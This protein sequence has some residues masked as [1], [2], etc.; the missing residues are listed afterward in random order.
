MIDEYLKAIIGDAQK[1]NEFQEKVF[2]KPDGTY[3]FTETGFEISPQKMEEKK[4]KPS[5]SD[6]P[7]KMVV[8]KLTTAPVEEQMD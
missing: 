6:R 2:F 5:P 8:S 1:E 3:T 4:K 7:N